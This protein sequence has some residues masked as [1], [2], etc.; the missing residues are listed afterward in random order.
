MPVLPGDHVDDHPHRALLVIEVAES[1]LHRDRAK[2]SLHAACGVPEYWLV[3]LE[4]DVVEVY[5]A[6]HDARYTQVSHHGRGETLG[7]VAL[8]EVAVSTHLAVPRRG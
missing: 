7:L 2:A 5:R 8:P 3:N 4:A 1:S 6:P